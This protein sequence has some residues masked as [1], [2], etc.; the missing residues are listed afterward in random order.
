MASKYAVTPKKDS[1]EEE[2]EKK[3]EDDDVKSEGGKSVKS[4]DDDDDE[5]ETM[6]FKYTKKNEDGSQE[7]IEEEWSVEH[8]KILYLMSK[9]AKAARKAD[10]AEGWIRQIPLLVL[11]YEGI[12]AGK[13]DFDYAPCSM[14]I[15]QDGR[16]RRVWLNITQEGKA[17]VDDVREK[18]V[19]NG[20]TLTAEDF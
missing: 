1:V 16:S 19:T 17:A 3:K 7:H 13:L 12:E 6:I 5:D 4:G 15:S 20:L 11:L 14:L 18:E 10:D 9:Y 8:A 2:A